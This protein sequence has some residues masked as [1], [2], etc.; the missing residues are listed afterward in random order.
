[1]TET[2]SPTKGA[3]YSLLSLASGSKTYAA[4]VDKA[5][6]IL[7]SSL[8]SS[9]SSRRRPSSPP[10]V[11]IAVRLQSGEDL[12][13]PVQLST[14]LS[15][16]PLLCAHEAGVPALDFRL[17]VEEERPA[18]APSLVSA[19]RSTATSFTSRER[20]KDTIVD[21]VNFMFLPE[22][23]NREVRGRGILSWTREY[24]MPHLQP[25]PSNIAQATVHLL[26]ERRGIVELSST[27]TISRLREAIERQTGLPIERQRIVMAQ[28]AQHGPFQ[29]LFWAVARLVYAAMLAVVG[30]VL[31]TA[32]WV[33][34]GGE[35]NHAITLQLRT[36]HGD[37]GGAGGGG[38][39]RGGK[40][41]C[42]KPIQLEVRKDMTLAQL[43][44]MVQLQHGDSVGLEGLILSS[45][46]GEDEED[47]DKNGREELTRP[48]MASGDGPGAVSRREL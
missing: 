42:S 15:Q 5:T 34:L 28:Q 32:R 10:P 3:M 18:S 9:L 47:K 24:I 33:A 39:G 30:F 35:S 6:Q 45:P 12:Y 20:V 11:L 14:S 22:A 43:Q 36:T 48:L 26:G 8:T 31:S 37:P 2:D 21:W 41:G 40:G 19:I 27:A 25:L 4:A 29:R 17:V 1:M 16:L 46:A 38:I 23:V 7:P 13:L 44:H